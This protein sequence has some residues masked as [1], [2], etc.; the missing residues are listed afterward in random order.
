MSTPAFGETTTGDEVV[1]KFKDRVVGKTVLITG[2]SQS[3][4]GGSTALALALGGV[5]TLILTGRT[6]S[7]VQPVIDAARAADSA[8]EV[9]FLKLDLAS[10]ASVRAAAATV[11]Q[12]V[13]HIDVLINNAGLSGKTYRKTADGIEEMFGV[14]HV[15]HWLLTSLLMPK[16]LAAPEPRVVNVSSSAHLYWDGSFEDYN[17]ER[18]RAYRPE[19]AYGQAKAANI[20]FTKALAQKFGDRGLKSYAVQPGCGDYTAEEFQVAYAAARASDLEFSETPKTVEQGCSTTLVAALD[21]DVP[22][23]IYLDDCHPKATSKLTQD[24]SLVD[25][26]WKISE[27]RAGEKFWSE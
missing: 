22:N 24:P 8:V 12:L 15:G 10:L 6:E 9:V 25:I 21:P 14:C 19:L 16:L 26:L 17:F 23:G 3:G 2:I 4:I 18:G 27:E 13:G 5:K 11:S 1:A 7:R 20:I